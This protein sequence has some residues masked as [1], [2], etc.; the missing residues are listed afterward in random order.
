MLKYFFYI[1]NGK[2]KEY[3]VCEQDDSFS[4]LPYSMFKIP[5]QDK[6]SV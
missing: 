4:P 1:K 2:I 5:I 6:E 3:I